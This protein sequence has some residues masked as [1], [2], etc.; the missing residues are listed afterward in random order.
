[1]IIKHLVIAAALSVAVFGCSKKDNEGAA[2]QPQQNTEKPAAT[3][4]P[5]AP[6]PA[7]AAGGAKEIFASRCTACHGESGKGDG[8]AA[9]A[10][11]PKPQDYTNKAWQ[12]EVTDEELKK[13]IVGGGAAVG[14]SAAMPPNPDLDGKPELD[15][16]V[17]IIR[18]FGK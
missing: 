12:A 9:A 17:A 11:N 2:P 16:L 13:A 5:A 18:A 8:A 15:G 1:M 3:A 6:A 14:K 4:A 7:A 10:L